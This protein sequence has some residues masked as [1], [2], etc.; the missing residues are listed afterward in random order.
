VKARAAAVRALRAVGAAAGP[1][2]LE[3]EPCPFFR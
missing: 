2:A 1:E 3:E